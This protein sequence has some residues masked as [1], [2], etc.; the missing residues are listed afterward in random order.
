MA[1]KKDINEMIETALCQ[2]KQFKE[3]WGLE[4]NKC[5]SQSF[6]KISKELEDAIVK[7]IKY[8]NKKK[9]IPSNNVVKYNLLELYSLKGKDQNAQISEFIN[10]E[11]LPSYLINE[12]ITI[13]S[14]QYVYV[15][16]RY[17]GM[18]CVVGK[19]QFKIKPDDS[20]T[21]YTLAGISLNDIGDLFKTIVIKDETKMETETD[22]SRLI[23]ELLKI[24]I[25]DYEVIKEK[26]Q[27]YYK[28]AFVIPI[29]GGEAE[30]I[31]IE[32]LLGN[33]LLCNGINI[34][35][36]NSHKKNK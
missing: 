26:M 30:A 20:S 3:Y 22:T 21:S 7:F 12:K 1:N 16:Q 36:K 25:A 24:S 17:D 9:L 10:K 13:N 4:N 23:Y 31:E 15:V 35:N 32:D 29:R 18:V 19:S 11:L 33:F 8:E 2:E 6:E 28:Q 5:D 14:L 34:L 27:K